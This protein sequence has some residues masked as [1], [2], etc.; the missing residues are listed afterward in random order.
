MTRSDSDQRQLLHGGRTTTPSDN[1][2]TNMNGVKPVLNQSMQFAGG[3]TVD[4]QKSSPRARQHTSR[5]WCSSTVTAL[6]ILMAALDVSLCFA[7]QDQPDREV[8]PKLEDMQ[9]PTAEELI[10]ADL[11]NRE[12]DWIVLKSD[13]TVIVA[14]PVFP[15]P[16]TLKRREEERKI[17]EATRPAN[18]NEREQRSKRLNELKSLIITLPGDLVTEYT[19][20]VNQI[21]QVILFEDLMLQRVDQLLEEGR[22]RQA[23]DLLLSVEQE[24]PGWESSAP[25]FEQ[26]LLTESEVKAKA[27][28]IYAA[29]A[30]LDE[31][32]ARNIDNPELQPRFGQ[33]VSPM[34]QAAFDQ[35]DYGKARFL[36]GRIERHFPQHPIAQQWRKQIADLATA[37]LNEAVE[38][39]RQKKHAEA[40]ELAR[41]AEAIWPLTGNA[42]VAYSQLIAR[43]QILRVAVDAFGNQPI[44]FPALLDADTRHEELVQVPLFEATSV[45]ELTYFR[46]SFF[47]KWDPADLGREVVMTLRS[48]RPHWQS[49]PVLT[50]NQIADTLSQRLD[51][52]GP[53]F[54][55]RLASFV[56]E[57]SVRS[58]TELKLSFSR[59]PL[60]IESLLRFP[61]TMYSSTSSDTQPTDK[62]WTLLSTRFALSSSGSNERRYLRSVPE[63][64]GLDNSQYHVAEIVEQKYTDRHQM[65]Q[66]LLRGEVD[67]LPNVLPWEI[68]AFRAANSLVAV[69]KAI[70]VTHVITLNPM[71][72]NIPNAQLRRALSMAIDR[73]SIL[74][75]IILKDP[76]SRHGRVTS[77]A[78]RKD[79]YATNPLEKAPPY[80]IRLAYALKFAAESQLKI[81]EMQV[82]EAAAKQKAKDA[83][84]EFDAETFRANVKLDYI[85]LPAL[86]MVVEPTEDALAAAERILV[87]W[88]KIGLEVQLIRGD[89]TGEPLGDQEWDLMYRRVRMEEPLLDLW[90]LV[91]NDPSFD[92][93]RLD[94]F[95]DW[96][97]QELI[98]LDYA[99]SFV[100]AQNRLFTIHRHIAAQAFVIPLWEVDEYMVF[101]KSITGFP[102]NPISTYQNVERWT[103]RP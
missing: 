24:M 53:L 10:Q 91:T 6:A 81:A 26:L 59:V 64:D 23:Y 48:T 13:G 20:P 87:Y 56:S 76:K 62:D 98:N 12:F 14:N 1:G 69:R 55:P 39:S 28:D 85:R 67:F 86:K 27:G 66:A 35:S 75:Q 21:D 78:W 42:R 47:E 25:R 57:F 43:H 89:E 74:S 50:A 32:A 18:A 11:K 65:M 82:L 31:L 100:E 80:D 34:I 52:Q 92:V 44:V 58:P 46:S 102:D 36:I 77:S 95:P 40:A 29:L 7:L 63:P 5:H 73:P 94:P 33:I 96:M 41:A 19:I 72:Q 22:I 61:V 9:L 45:D 79:S 51:P 71:S 17:L 101:Q 84:E 49:Q 99:G 8:L 3:E 16:D 70:P 4:R 93:R 15:R 54:D 60:S 68:D 37:K 88:K 83:K 30:L 38:F 97:R 103:V 90:P 2:K